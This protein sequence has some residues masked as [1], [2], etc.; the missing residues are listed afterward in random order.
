MRTGRITRRTDEN[1]N[2]AHYDH[3]AVT[4]AGIKTFGTGCHD[5]II[6][7]SELTD[8]LN[9]ITFGENSEYNNIPGYIAAQVFPANT[10]KKSKGFAAVENDEF[11]VK[12][13][14]GDYATSG[15]VSDEAAARIAA[16]EVLAEDIDD[17]VDKV[18]GY[19]LSKNDFTDLLK[20]AYDGAVAALPLSNVDVANSVF[21]LDTTNGL[22]AIAD[23]YTLKKNL[24]LL[25]NQVSQRVSL[26]TS[27]VITNKWLK[28]SLVGLLGEGAADTGMTGLFDRNQLTNAFLKPGATVTGVLTGAGSAQAVSNVI[29]N[30]AGD[31]MNLIGTDATSNYV[32]TIDLGYSVSVYGRDRWVPFVVF[33]IN[34]YYFKNIAVEVSSNGTDWCVPATAGQWSTTN[35]GTDQILGT[36]IWMAGEYKPIGLTGNTWRYA[37]FTMSEAVTPTGVIYITQLGIRHVSHSY[38]PQYILAAG[39]DIYGPL[40]LKVINPSSGAGDFLKRL[41]LNG[42]IVSRTASQALSD[43]GAASL[44]AE[45]AINE[46][47]LS[48]PSDGN[49]LKKLADRL[50]TLNAI[51]TDN[52]AA[53]AANATTIALKSNN[54]KTL[55]TGKTAS[56][57][58]DSANNDCVIPVLSTVAVTITLPALDVGFRTVIKQQGAGQLTFV[59]DTGITIESSGN[60]KKSS[61]Q[62]AEIVVSAYA[63]DR[64]TLSGDLTV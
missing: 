62:Y 61:A 50:T 28:N 59:A 14:L 57:T 10:V 60:R 11:V 35:F 5:N 55:I 30:A 18:T 19:G 27:D 29:F 37:R 21:A 12:G 53:A 31:F 43:I 16:D 24:K 58:L 33:R 9:G 25:Q 40:K 49:T 63:T 20:T 52:T 17:K 34:T 46:I 38:A 15:S 64:V 44:A 45:T 36:A 23:S 22:T 47:V 42:E 54:L 6:G 7:F 4:F 56:F 51:V 48:A 3:R 8:S 26:T 13:Q 1:L 32:I 41:A 2:E 39:D